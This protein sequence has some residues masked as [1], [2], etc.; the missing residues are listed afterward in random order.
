[1][2]QP[3]VQ[4]LVNSSM[5]GLLIWSKIFAYI[6]IFQ[7]NMI[8]WYAFIT[9][10]AILFGYRL[11][12]PC[13]L[14]IYLVAED[15]VIKVNPSNIGI[16][17]SAAEIFFGPEPG[18][19]VPN[20]IIGLSASMSSLSVLINVKH[21]GLFAYGLDGQ[22]RWTAGPVLHQFGYHQGCK[23]NVR[24]CYFTSIPVIDRCEANIYV[25]STILYF[26]SS[27]FPIMRLVY[28]CQFRGSSENIQV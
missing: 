5:K 2:K 8:P 1:M 9:S 21:R 6:Y 27:L 11:M 24:D 12:Q 19:E 20:E 7:P 25:R 26:V 23:Q 17:E 10:S 22:L 18:Q 13:S 4:Y 3:R 15:K 14:Q 28:M 16:N